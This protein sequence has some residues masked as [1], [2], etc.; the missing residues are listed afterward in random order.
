MKKEKQKTLKQL[1]EQLLN[2]VKEKYYGKDDAITECV[3][4]LNSKSEQL[5]AKREKRLQRVNKAEDK[6]KS[7]SSNISLETLLL[8]DKLIIKERWS[9]Q[10]M[11]YPEIDNLENASNEI[12][13]AIFEK[14]EEH[15]KV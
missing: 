1:Q 9:N 13:M 12:K 3:N 15:G 11:G 2:L 8:C 5:R 10:I 6:N 4:M 7:K 14:G